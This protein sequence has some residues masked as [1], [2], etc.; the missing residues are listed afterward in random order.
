MDRS[1]R[2][3]KWENDHWR[4]RIGGH[5]EE[6]GG[7]G[8]EER[9][10]GRYNTSLHIRHPAW[11]RPIL[12]KTGGQARPGQAGCLKPQRKKRT[13]NERRIPFPRSSLPLAC[14]PPLPGTTTASPPLLNSGR[15]CAAEKMSLH[16]R[17]A[18]PCLQQCLRKRRRRRRR[19]R[20]GAPDDAPQPLPPL[21]L[22]DCPRC[23]RPRRRRRRHSG[24]DRVQ[25]VAAATEWRAGERESERE[26]PQSGRE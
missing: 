7:E 23:C 24:F 6:R 12:L 16:F 13:I 11:Q 5:A 10:P 14:L 22:T 18:L 17:V 25:P 19:R 21:F 8:G 3:E 9:E 2:K 4:W 20:A 15:E 26:F 1:K